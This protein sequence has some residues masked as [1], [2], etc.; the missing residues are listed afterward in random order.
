MHH[1]LKA[2]DCALYLVDDKTK[3]FYLAKDASESI[4]KRFPFNTGIAGIVAANGTTI[5][6]STQAHKDPRFHPEVDQ[7]R[8][9]TTHSILC[10]PIK[11]EMPDDQT[12][13]IGMQHCAHFVAVHLFNEWYP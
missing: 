4:A 5:R 9:K 11:A 3:E 2:D 13:I 12:S 7:R 10:C 8:D 1:L 6:I